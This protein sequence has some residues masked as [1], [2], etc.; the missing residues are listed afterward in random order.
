MI[1]TW[2]LNW[3]KIKSAFVFSQLEGLGSGVT[4]WAG[5]LSHFQAFQHGLVK[6]SIPVLEEAVLK[7][8]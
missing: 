3:F 8:L 5:S 4:G 6:M 2:F 1:R 7:S